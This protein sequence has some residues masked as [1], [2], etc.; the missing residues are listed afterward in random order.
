MRGHKDDFSDDLIV[1]V[2]AWKLVASCLGCAENICVTHTDT[3]THTHMHTC[4]Q[5]LCHKYIHTHMH[6]PSSTCGTWGMHTSLCWT[7]MPLPPTLHTGKTRVVQIEVWPKIQVHALLHIV[8]NLI[9]AIRNSVKVR[10]TF[11]IHRSLQHASL[12]LTRDSS[13]PH[14]FFAVNVLCSMICIYEGTLWTV[15]KI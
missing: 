11:R 7:A 14:S 10:Q 12:K 4:R 6:R 15:Q 9:S 1:C 13:P 3:H 8:T 2:L 5:Q